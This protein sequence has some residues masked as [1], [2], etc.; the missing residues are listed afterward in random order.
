[1]KDSELR[2]ARSTCQCKLNDPRLLQLGHL[3]APVNL[4]AADSLLMSF[5]EALAAI[6]VG[7][8]ILLSAQTVK[9]PNGLFDRSLKECLIQSAPEDRI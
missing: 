6:A 9:R 7:G 3:P 4:A 2:N 8:D 5:A 1:M